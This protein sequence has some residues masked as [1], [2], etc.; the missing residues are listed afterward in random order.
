[1]IQYVKNHKKSITSGLIQQ[2][3]KYIISERKNSLKMIT[4][5]QL[6]VLRQNKSK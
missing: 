1:M 2:T 4:K 3:K 6:T 5:K